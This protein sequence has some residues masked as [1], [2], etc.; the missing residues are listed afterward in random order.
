MQ[1]DRV[2]AWY[3]GKSA[4]S[5]PVIDAGEEPK[6][7]RGEVGVQLDAKCFGTSDEGLDVIGSD[8]IRHANPWRRK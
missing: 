3:A 7:G 8:R 5:V 1:S 4:E 2:L 6:Q